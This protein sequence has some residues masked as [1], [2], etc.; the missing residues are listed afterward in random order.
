MK[1]AFLDRDGTIIK[2]YT[3]EEWSHVDTPDF[4]DGSLEAMRLLNS[5]DYQIVFITNQYLIQENY[6]N[7]KKF[8]QF[9]MKINEEIHHHDIKIL[10]LFYCPHRRDSQCACCKPKIGLIEMALSKYPKIK[11]EDSFMCGDSVVDLR[12][13][14]AMNLKVFG[15]DVEVENIISTK[16]KSLKDVI[17][18]LKEECVIKV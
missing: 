18:Y 15:I 6:I 9:Q 16:V 1:V 2:D 17:L 14:D 5:L 13:A 12:L 11:L 10:D 8:L 4:L 3:D 7:Y